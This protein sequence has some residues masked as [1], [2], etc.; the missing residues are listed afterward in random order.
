MKFIADNYFIIIAVAVFLLL[1][2]IGYLIDSEKNKKTNNESVIEEE[3]N[4]KI[5]NVNEENEEESTLNEKISE[6]PLV[7][8]EEKVSK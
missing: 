3:S 5:L 2:L 8:E 4:Q 1:A 6:I 7:D